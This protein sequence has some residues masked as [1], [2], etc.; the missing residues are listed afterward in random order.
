MLAESVSPQW[1]VPLR[2]ESRGAVA[3][4]LS[5]IVRPAPLAPTPARGAGARRARLRQGEEA[6]LLRA[7]PDTRGPAR[8]SPRHPGRPVARGAPCRW[9][10]RVRTPAAP[11]PAGRRGCRGRRCSCCRMV[12]SKVVIGDGRRPASEAGPRREHHGCLA[13]PGTGEETGF[14]RATPG[15]VRAERAVRPA[16]TREPRRRSL[17]AGE[18]GGSAARGRAPCLPSDRPSAPDPPREHHGR[19]RRAVR[20]QPSAAV[21]RQPSAGRGPRCAVTGT[22]R[23]PRPTSPPYPGCGIAPPR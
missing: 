16:S 15:A 22:R 5:R 10:A 21:S 3:P 17:A 23:P 1:P 2:H 13:R 12:T 8:S 19:A 14:L 9:R 20:G 7:A 4:W 6:R 11:L 18:R